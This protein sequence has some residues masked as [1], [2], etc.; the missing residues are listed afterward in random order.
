MPC[1]KHVPFKGLEEDQRVLPVAAIETEL[2]QGHLGCLRI[3]WGS[4]EGHL[5]WALTCP[6]HPHSP[7]PAAVTAAATVH[8]H[9]SITN[10]SCVCAWLNAGTA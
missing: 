2:A 10:L 4:D 1:A 6:L 5:H 9:C 8:T 7:T 3:L